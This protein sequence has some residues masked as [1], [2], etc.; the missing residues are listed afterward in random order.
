MCECVE[1]YELGVP[2][3][4]RLSFPT[5]RGFVYMCFLT[6]TIFCNQLN[7]QTTCRYHT[8]ALPKPSLYHLGNV[9]I[10]YDIQVDDNFKICWLQTTFSVD[11]FPLLPVVT[12][13][14]QSPHFQLIGHCVQ[15]WPLICQN[16]RTFFTTMLSWNLNNYYHIIIKRRK[17]RRY[18]KYWQYF[19]SGF[20][21]SLSHGGCWKVLNRK[22]PR[23]FS[24][25]HHR[26]WNLPTLG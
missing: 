2:E 10:N 7:V 16:F 4:Y 20:N 1:P 15:I 14:G 12:V 17:L 13:T 6:F 3:L 23:R 9:G 22:V 18:G 11:K 8:V 24:M 19:H 21:T 25:G 26:I 5:F